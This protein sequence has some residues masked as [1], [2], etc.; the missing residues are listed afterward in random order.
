MRGSCLFVVKMSLCE[1]REKGRQS[2][3]Q[4]IT[5][6]TAPARHE[7][8]ALSPQDVMLLWRCSSLILLPLFDTCVAFLPIHSVPTALFVLILLL[9]STTDLP[10]FAPVPLH[11]SPAGVSLDLFFSDCLRVQAVSSG[12]SLWDP[13]L[14]ESA[15]PLPGDSH[16]LLYGLLSPPVPEVINFTTHVVL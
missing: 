2:M 12:V 4:Q 8:S 16:D 10:N 11:L 3:N 5:I 14:L 9:W 6:Y 15:F 1:T 7:E 13:I